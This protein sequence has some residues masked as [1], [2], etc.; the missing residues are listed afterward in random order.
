MYV[1]LPFQE[2][3]QAERVIPKDPLKKF[4]KKELG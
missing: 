4:A 1:T 3:G 2:L